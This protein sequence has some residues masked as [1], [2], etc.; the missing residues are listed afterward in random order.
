MLFDRFYCELYDIFEEMLPGK[1]EEVL[2]DYLRRVNTYVMNKLHSALF[3]A[4]VE[5]LRK[6]DEEYQEKINSIQWVTPQHLEVPLAEKIDDYTFELVTSEPYPLLLNTATYIF[7][8]DS[9][10]LT[11]LF[12]LAG[13]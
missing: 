1:S 2:E 8:L 9:E 11:A 7:P 5:S 4:C 12:T 10:L 3:S 13:F 6:D